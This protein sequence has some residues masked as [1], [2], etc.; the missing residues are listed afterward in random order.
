MKVSNENTAPDENEVLV[1]SAEVR[2]I[3][4]GKDSYEVSFLQ[5][6]LSFFGKLEVFSVLGAA[7]DK[8]M[9]GPDGLTLGELFDGPA[10]MGKELNKQNFRDAD[11]FV[12]GVAKLVQYAPDLLADLYLIFLS[13]PRGERGIVKEMMERPADEGGLSDEDGLGILETFVDQNWDV[14]LD[15]FTSKILPLVNKIN[16][17]VQESQPSKP[18]KTTRRTTPKQ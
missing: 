6:P 9:S 2:T 14:M 16:T 13:V 11:T 1:P 5:K 3:V 17:K 12:K 4:L 15:F 10:S 18:S 7:L 8:A